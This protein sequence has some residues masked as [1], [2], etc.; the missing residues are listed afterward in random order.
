MRQLMRISTLLAIWLLFA[1]TPESATARGVDE[2]CRQCT[3]W[4]EAGVVHKHTATLSA[5]MK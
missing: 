2:G 5:N 4:Y 1:V 3:S